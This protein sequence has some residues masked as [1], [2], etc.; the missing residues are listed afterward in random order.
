[1]LSVSYTRLTIINIE[2]Y[3]GFNRIQYFKIFQLWYIIRLVSDSSPLGNSMTAQINITKHIYVYCL[4]SSLDID[5]L[6]DTDLSTIYKLLIYLPIGPLFIY[7]Y[8]L[9]LNL[10]FNVSTWF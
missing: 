2:T 1:M 8:L 9:P 3:K 10:S 5:I 7:T 4:C 6:D